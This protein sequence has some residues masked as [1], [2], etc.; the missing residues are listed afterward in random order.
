MVKIAQIFSKTNNHI[1][2]QLMEHKKIMKYLGFGL[3]Q[4]DIFCEVL[5]P[6]NAITTLTS[7][8]LIIE[9]PMAIHNIKTCTD[10]VLFKRTTC[11]HI[12]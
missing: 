6:V 8:L 5:N 11:Y 9:S 4:A 10:P 12:K 3:G 1:L 7:C 2:S